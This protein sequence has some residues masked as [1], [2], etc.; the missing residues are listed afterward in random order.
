[1]N[2]KELDH[3][4]R[5]T[6]DPRNLSTELTNAFFECKA[7]QERKDGII[8]RH[9]KLIE[10]RGVKLSK[11]VKRIDNGSRMVEQFFYEKIGSGLSGPEAVLSFFDEGMYLKTISFLRSIVEDSKNLDWKY[12]EAN[13]R[14]D[15]MGCLRDFGL[16]EEAL[17]YFRKDYLVFQDYHS[18][19]NT[20]PD[21]SRVSKFQIVRKS[22]D[23][24]GDDLDMSVFVPYL[25]NVGGHESGHFLL[26]KLEQKKGINYTEFYDV[27]N[28]DTIGE[29]FASFWGKH[30]VVEYMKTKNKKWDATKDYQWKWWEKEQEF[31]KACGDSLGIIKN[32]E[33]M[34][35]SLFFK[36][37]TETFEEDRGLY[38]KLIGDASALLET[39]QRTG[40]PLAKRI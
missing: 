3:G 10:G 16:S 8:Q 15:F 29:P 9:E 27:L 4:L 1:M 24:S 17:G 22:M 28:V 18:S 32:M 14:K 40:S 31:E 20:G 23:I 6:T 12:Y 36:T 39:L 26:N 34:A 11:H 5:T 7:F 13:L 37:V 35:S 30:F 25:Y 38:N 2:F 33:S 21:E 19:S